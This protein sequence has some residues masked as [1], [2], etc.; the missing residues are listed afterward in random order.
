MSNCIHCLGTIDYDR[1]EFLQQFNKP[2]TC[3]S[4]SMEQPT[5]GYKDKPKS[6]KSK[7]DG[8]LKKISEKYEQMKQETDNLVQKD[9]KAYK[10][11]SKN[12]TKRKHQKRK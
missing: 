1:L 10:N 4:C 3:K 2:Q 7:T 9:L 8:Q 6:I 5:V 11:F 12:K